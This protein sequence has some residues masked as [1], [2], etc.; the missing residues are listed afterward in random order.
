MTK[1]KTLDDYLN[2]P[3]LAGEPEALRE[4]HA[5]RLKIHDERKGMTAAEYNAIVHQ[6]AVHFL[7]PE[8]PKVTVVQ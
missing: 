8:K 3:E 4:V 2:D 7:S 1:T 5:I 6:R